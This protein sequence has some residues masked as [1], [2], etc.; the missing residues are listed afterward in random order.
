MR[1]EGG[2]E[3][4]NVED[5]RGQSVGGGGGGLPLGRLLLG[6]GGGLGTIIILIILAVVFGSQF[7]GGGGDDQPDKVGNVKGNE[8]DMRFVR[9]IMGET[10]SVWGKLFQQMGKE[11]RD[12]KLRVFSER[13]RSGCG[14][15]DAGM[16]PFYCPADQKIYLDLEF[17][18][19]LGHRFKAPG[20]FAQAYVIAH[21]VGH[22]VQNL[23]GRLQRTHERQEALLRSGNK[24]EANHESV[25]LELHADFLAGVWAH[26]AQEAKKW[27]EPGDLE[28]AI[29]AAQ[30]I[31]DDRLQKDAKGWVNPDTFT[32]GRSDQR[33]K[34]FK[35]GFTTGD[36]RKGDALFELPYNQL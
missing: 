34:W 7:F 32:H 26:H 12:P 3:S 1:W 10:E 15:A 8:E 9:V 25:R 16:G 23:T 29:K 4:G 5:A 2:R 14:L 35:L 30:A 21:E 28:S 33:I 11:Y 6:G 31:G 36:I 17:F 19:E 24:T 22:H 20:R 18:G 13:T 27:M